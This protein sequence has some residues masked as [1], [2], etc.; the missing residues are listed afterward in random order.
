MKRFQNKGC[1]PSRKNLAFTL[2]EVLIT[3]GIIGIV[4]AMTLPTLI[5]K[6]QE[7]ETVAKL[8]KFNTIINQAYMLAINANGY[9]EDWGLSKAGT[10]QEQ[11]DEEV[12]DGNSARDKFLDK[13]ISYLKV[14]SRC[15]YTEENCYS[16]DR[17]SLDG[18]QFST[19][20]NRLTLADGTT[21]VGL[22][23]L[24]EKCSIQHGNSKV[25]KNVCGEIF[26]DLNGPK[27]PNTT[28]KDVFLFL[29]T[30]YGI[31]PVGLPDTFENRHSFEISCNLSNPYR[32]NG[33]GCAAWIIYNGNMDYLHCNDL[34]WNGKRKCK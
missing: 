15:K 1:L 7:K 34:S 12:A 5:Q 6:N 28:G 13:L 31:V 11:T 23:I 25:L 4:A 32:L 33:Y 8:R 16:Y 3:L 27:P 9:V 22:T 26:V 21:I 24:D 10:G 17:Y 29:Y 20:T 2:A 14:N 19:F 30:K 18:T